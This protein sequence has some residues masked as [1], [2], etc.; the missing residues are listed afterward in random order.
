[1]SSFAAVWAWKQKV[2]PAAR[3]FVLL[4]LSEFADAEGT[5]R[6]SQVELAE[7]TEQTER[8]V[9]SHLIALEE[10]GLISRA[11]VY[12]DMGFRDV[13]AVRLIAPKSER[14][15]KKAAQDD[16]NLSLP[17]EFS[18][19]QNLAEKFSGSTGSL[20]EKFSGQETSLFLWK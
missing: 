3:K 6:V 14:R 13:D 15:C 16:G 19:S 17:A 1:M 4:A 20:P 9:R 7:L 11:A 8:S 18:G 2:S 12:D 10:D 5:C